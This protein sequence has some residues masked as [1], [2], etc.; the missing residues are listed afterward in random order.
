MTTRPIRSFFLSAC[1][2]IGV[3][4]AMAD[5]VV[6][7]YNTYCM[8]C[9]G[10]NLKGGLGTNLLDEDAW[11]RVGQGKGFIEYVKE[12]NIEAGM[13]S[14]GGAIEDPMIRALEIYIDERRKKTANKGESK[15]APVDGVY[16]K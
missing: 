4:N 6:E 3:Q 2:F 10:E 16:Q 8:S 14:F 15:A 5:D 1:S 11:K 7:V 13:P 12:G 9:H